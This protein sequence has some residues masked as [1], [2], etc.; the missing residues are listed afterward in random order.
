MTEYRINLD[1]KFDLDEANQDSSPEEIAAFV[2]RYE[3]AAQRYAE[4]H[5]ISIEIVTDGGETDNG[6]ELEIWQAIHYSV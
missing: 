4:N 1:A 6:D 2:R 5:N 3:A